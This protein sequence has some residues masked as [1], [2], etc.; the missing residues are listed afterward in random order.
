MQPVS[1]WILL[2]DLCFH[3]DYCRI[4]LAAEGGRKNEPFFFLVSPSIHQSSIRGHPIRPSIH[5]S[6]NPSILSIRITP[7]SAVE[8][9]IRADGG[10]SGLGVGTTQRLHVMLHACVRLGDSL[11][12]QE[13]IALL[14]PLHLG[15]FRV[16][17]AKLVPHLIFRCLRDSRSSRRLQ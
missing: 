12:R 7:H 2:S 16:Y 3:C 8:G 5:Q 9:V 11:P 10:K 13:I 6:V 17:S 14:S 4:C 15:G 1:R